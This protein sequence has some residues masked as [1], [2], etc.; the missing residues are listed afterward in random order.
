MPRNDSSEVRVLVADDSA[1]FRRTLCA[2]LD[3][4]P[5]VSV[6]G[7]AS[8]ADE[9]VVVAERTEPDVVLLDLVMPRGGGCEALRRIK[10]GSSRARVILL[11]VLGKRELAHAARSAG[12]DDFLCK[13]DIDE[14]L[15]RVLGRESR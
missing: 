15:P 3:S 9:A 6:V 12:A 2:F 7:E 13:A 4:M 14:E 11:S 10:G 8:D 1:S 5:G